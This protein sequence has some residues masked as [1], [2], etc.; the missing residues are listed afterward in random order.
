MDFINEKEDQNREDELVK[1]ILKKS[2]RSVTIA[3]IYFVSAF[4]ILFGEV[5]D[6]NSWFNLEHPYYL[7]IS[8]LLFGVIFKLDAIHL[9]FV[10]KHAQDRLTKSRITNNF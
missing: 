10:W 5:F 1:K 3:S 6:I 2:N 8:L 7:S 9:F 4:L